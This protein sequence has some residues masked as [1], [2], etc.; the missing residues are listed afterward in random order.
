MILLDTHVMIWLDIDRDR[1]GR[2]CLQRIAEVEAVAEVAFSAATIWELT[3]LV[4]KGKLE[5]PQPLA[6]W[7]REWLDAETTEVAIDGPIILE[8]AALAAFHPDPADRFIVATAVAL[9]AELVTADER[10]LSWDGPVRL[11][12]ARL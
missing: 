6:S 3:F 8:A 7:R 1:V 12:D 2:A 11:R 5:L 4:A 9:D 10:I